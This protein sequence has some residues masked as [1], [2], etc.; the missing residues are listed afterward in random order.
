VEGFR[1]VSTDGDDFRFEYSTDGVTF[2]P[3][4]L[5]SLP[6]SDDDTDLVG[7]LPADLTG[8]VTIRVVDTDRSA[9]NQT[10]D[11]VSIDELFVRAIP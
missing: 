8:T 9:G 10:L 1:S 3:V 4:A 5:A 11:A 7:A 6:S 2:T